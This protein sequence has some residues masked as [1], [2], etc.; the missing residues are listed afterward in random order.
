[1]TP[2]TTQLRHRPGS[3]AVRARAVALLGALCAAL[4]LG[5]AAPHP[6]AASGP[7][8]TTAAAPQSTRTPA[9][10]D[11]VRG[12]QTLFTGGGR[13]MVAYNATD[14]SDYFG[15]M[16]G[17][18]GTAGTQWYAD[19]GLTVPV[20]TTHA[21]QFPG[22]SWSVVRY[23]NPDLDYPSEVVGGGAPVRV[24]GAGSPSVG[25]S[26]CRFG[27][28]TGHLC[29]TVLAL[30]QTINYP[31]GAVT[32]LFSTNICAEPGD[33]GGPVLAGGTALGILVGGSGN[34]ATGGRT[35]YQPVVPVLSTLGLTIGY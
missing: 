31:E 7:D 10:V 17:H 32:G 18:C 3:R 14:G 6:A 33:S 34:C 26:V 25:Q 4:A 20:G 1:M 15:L 5:L 23:T 30:N 28:T 29:G 12:G 27:S 22:S 16:A 8:T 24:T 21:A 13:C 19:A 2:V 35:Y 11:A 9:A